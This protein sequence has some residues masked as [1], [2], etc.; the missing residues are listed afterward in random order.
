MTVARIFH[1]LTAPPA[2]PLQQSVTQ[3]LRHT[4]TELLQQSVSRLSTFTQLQR[5]DATLA[6][7]DPQGGTV[8]LTARW[9]GLVWTVHSQ[10][11]GTTGCRQPLLLRRWLDEEGSM[12]FEME[13]PSL[14]AGGRPVVA[15]RRFTRKQGSRAPEYVQLAGTGHHG[16]AEALSAEAQLGGK[17]SVALSSRA[18]SPPPAQQPAPVSLPP[19]PPPPQQQQQQLQSVPA[20]A[21]PQ[22]QPA[23]RRR[24]ARVPA[25]R[26]LSVEEEVFENSRSIPMLGWSSA[27]LL[28]TDPCAWSSRDGTVGS[29]E[30]FPDAPLPRGW[31]WLSA[32]SVESDSGTGGAGNGDGWM[33]SHS[34]TALAQGAPHAGSS[35]VDGPAMMVRRRRWVRTRGCLVAQQA[36]ALA[37]GDTPSLGVPATPAS[38]LPRVAESLRGEADA[39]PE[40]ALTPPPSPPPAFR[41]AGGGGQGQGPRS[42][43]TG[44]S[45][46]AELD[47]HGDGAQAEWSR[48]S[49]AA[50][51]L[52]PGLT[53]TPGAT[54]SIPVG[55]QTPWRLAEQEIAAVLAASREHRPSRPASS[56]SGP[57]DSTSQPRRASSHGGSSVAGDATAQPRVPLGRAARERRALSVGGGSSASQTSESRD[58]PAPVAVAVRARR[59]AGGAAT[60]AGALPGGMTSFRGGSVDPS[61]SIFAQSASL[62]ETLRRAQREYAAFRADG[63][64]DSSTLRSTLPAGVLPR[65]P[66][67]VPARSKSRGVPAGSIGADALRR[68]PLVSSQR[69]VQGA[70]ARLDHAAAR[71][72]R[73]AICALARLL[74]VTWTTVQPLLRR[75]AVAL[76]VLAAVHVLLSLVL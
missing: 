15:L 44:S 49:A 54:P 69:G 67:L 1:A 17:G 56:H 62:G 75:H 4:P 74:R 58:A 48:R 9:D 76:S 64:V 36:G 63:G 43:T 21:Q 11:V 25:A 73:A 14:R 46:V 34:F 37:D 24:T 18:A 33:Y 65:A 40:G 13:T 31:H 5:I 8:Q 27:Y 26:M 55:P 38:Q 3:L 12:W 2:V 29:R 68:R 22:P 39:A 51:R 30:T 60:S 59:G 66:P 42:S 23:A 7:E 6:N 35:P 71:M 20:A 61:A 41:A 10:P 70:V 16:S 45:S 52:A 32:W 47:P 28:A 19:P 50:A 57:T 72:Q 53:G